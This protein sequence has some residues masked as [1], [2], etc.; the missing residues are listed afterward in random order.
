MRVSAATHVGR[1]RALNED[2]FY[3][4]THLWVVA[5]GM[6]GHAAGDVAARL[7]VEALA[8]IDRPGLALAEV[9]EAIQE[10]NAHLVAYGDTHPDAAGLGTTL[11]GLVEVNLGGAHHWAIVNVGDSR[12]YHLAGGGLA[13]ATID[14][15]EVEELVMAGVITEAEARLR[16]DRNIITRS[17]GSVP[18]PQVDA[19]VLPQTE[20]ERFLLCTDGVHG[21]LDDRQIAAIVAHPDVQTA[22]ADLVDQ[23]LATSARDNLTAVLVEVVSSTDERADDT[24]NPRPRGEE[25]R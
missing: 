12:V 5:D 23:V 11:T 7:A 17:L 22:V 4:G 25:R 3:A 20:G 2:A 16:P 21:E 13:R 14:H 1:V 8:A 24:T 6:G 19:W 18:S 9:E 10:A 15:S